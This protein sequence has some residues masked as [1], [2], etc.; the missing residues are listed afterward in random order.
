MYSESQTFIKGKIEV[1]DASNPL[2]RAR[3]VAGQVLSEVRPDLELQ[4][5]TAPPPSPPPPPP[6]ALPSARST[7]ILGPSSDAARH[8]RA[9]RAGNPTSTGGGAGGGGGS[10]EPTEDAK[11][12]LLAKQYE[13]S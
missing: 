4:R 13:V 11:T 12:K 2:P 3:R 6:L 7:A 1:V 10:G 8:S 5:N 9:A